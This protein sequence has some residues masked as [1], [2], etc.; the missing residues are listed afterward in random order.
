MSFEFS[1]EIEEQFVAGVASVKEQETSGRDM[2]QKMLHL[3]T[4]RRIYRNHGSSHRK[5]PKDIVGC[6]YKA[7]GIVSFAREL[8][9]TMGIKLFPNLSS[10]RK[11]EF[12]PIDSAY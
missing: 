6:G 3:I 4:F 1:K 5:L 8:E 10:G 7:L 11:V 9:P 12:R 2:L